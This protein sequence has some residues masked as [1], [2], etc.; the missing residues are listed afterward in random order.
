M[1]TRA[2]ILAGV[3]ASASSGREFV[4][5]FDALEEKTP[6]AVYPLVRGYILNRFLLPE[7]L[8]RSDKLLDLADESLR[9]VLELK[10]QGIVLTDISHGCSGASSVVT[11]KVLLMKAIREEFRVPISPEISGRLTTVTEV[12]QYIA[13]QYQ[14]GTLCP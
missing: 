2:E 4:T 7:A 6:A 1:A 3:R 13:S 8:A 5:A 11:K 9:H 12:A 10:K 14:E